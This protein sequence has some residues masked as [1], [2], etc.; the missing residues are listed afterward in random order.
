PPVDLEACM[1]LLT[2]PRNRLYDLHFVRDLIAEAR[3]RARL[4]RDRPPA[5]PRRMTLRL[6]DEPYTAPRNGFRD[7]ADYYR[8]PSAAQFVPRIRVPTLILAAR[9]DPFVAAEPI[10]RLER[11]TCVEVR[12]TDHGGHVGYLGRDG[13]GGF[14]WGERAVVGWLTNPVSPAGG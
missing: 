3:R 9:D 11:P 14:C 6:F 4:F 13:A 7:A 5:F 8:Q 12:L 10:E 2:H 1:A